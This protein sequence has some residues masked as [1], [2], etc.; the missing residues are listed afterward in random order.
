MDQPLDVDFRPT[1]NHLLQRCWGRIHGLLKQAVEE[2][3][4]TSRS[5]S[6]ETERELIQVVVRMLRGRGAL[7][8]ADNPTLE[9]ADNQVNVGQGDVCRVATGPDADRLVVIAGCCKPLVAAPGVGE[10]G[11]ARL[12]RLP[13][14]PELSEHEL[15]TWIEEPIQE[16]ATGAY[17]EWEN[18]WLERYM[19]AMWAW[20]SGRLEPTRDSLER[21]MIGHILPPPPEFTSLADYLAAVRRRVESPADGWPSQLELPRPAW[22]TIGAELRA[23]CS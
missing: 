21:R 18:P 19:E 8:G 4:A 12:D 6:V 20:L 14:I 16:V 23:A 5:A 1:T 3:A 22:G 7:V 11:G 10:D 2:E 15:L 9:Q 13:G 17:R